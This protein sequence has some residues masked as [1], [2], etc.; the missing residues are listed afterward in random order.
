M[1]LVDTLSLTDDS[2]PSNHPQIEEALYKDEWARLSPLFHDAVFGPVATRPEDG[3]VVRGQ[4]RFR[5]MP[6]ARYLGEMYEAFKPGVRLCRV[7]CRWCFMYTDSNALMHALYSI[8]TG[9]RLWLHQRQ[10]LHA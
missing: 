4:G 7:G 1:I 6:I 8:I 9:G 2:P 10:P 3:Y 5:E